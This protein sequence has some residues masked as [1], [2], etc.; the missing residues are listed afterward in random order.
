MWT[1]KATVLPSSVKLLDYLSEIVDDDSADGG[2]GLGAAMDMHDDMPVPTYESMEGASAYDEAT[3]GEG[4][5][6]A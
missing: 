2:G 4:R 5:E 6:A 3:A 1:W